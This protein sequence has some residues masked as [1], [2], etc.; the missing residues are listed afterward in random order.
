MTA[1]RLLRS[2]RRRGGR[3]SSRLRR[4]APRPRRRRRRG[5]PPHRRVRARR[6]ACTPSA[7]SARWA[8]AIGTRRRGRDRRRPRAGRDDDR[9][10]R[11]AA[12]RRAGDHRAAH[13]HR[14]AQ[15]RAVPAL[16]RGRWPKA[17]KPKARDGDVIPLER[18]DPARRARRGASR[19]ST[20]WPAA[21]TPTTVSE[22]VRT[23]RRG[24]RRAGRRARRRPS[25]RPPGSPRRWPRSTR[26]WSTRPTRSTCWPAR[27]SSARQQLG[28]ARAIVLRR[29]RG[30]GRRA[31]GHP[32]VPRRPSSTSPSRAGA[33]STTYGE[34]LPQDIA[35]FTALADAARRQLATP[36]SSWSSAFPEVAEGIAARLP[37]GHRRHLPAG[38]RHAHPGRPPRGV[39]RPARRAAP[40]PAP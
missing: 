37:A 7:T 39:P 4:G 2:A 13:A 23:R 31:R 40:E 10:R 12:R 5:L 20:S 21:S 16:G 24:H 27:S 34:Q 38:Q 22:L 32:L 18:T 30:A 1:R 29:D 19:R 26:S 28:V 17:G 3:R 14:R 25:T 8:S 6:R 9:R 15:R 36:P 33:S 35:H 11:P